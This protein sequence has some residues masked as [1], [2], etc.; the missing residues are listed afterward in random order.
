MQRAYD[1]IIHDVALQNLNVVFCL[2]RAGI[3]GADGATHHGAFDIAFMRSIPNMT[4][5][6]PMDECELRNMMF[7]AQNRPQ[8]PFSI[9]YPRGKTPNADWQK[10][11]ELIPI[12]KG[13]TLREGSSLAILTIGNTGNFVNE[14]SD[15]LLEADIDY[16]HYDM[17]F[18]KPIDEELL[19]KVFKKFTKIITVEDGVLKGGFGSA[20]LEFM[21]DNQYNAEVVRLGI[22]D[23][24]VE[25]GASHELYEICGYSP[26]DILNTAKKMMKPAIA[27]H[28]T[29][30]LRILQAFKFFKQ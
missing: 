26:N 16:A 23:A 18:V 10:P 19:H 25:H 13:R 7:T 9:R 15:K 12:G 28:E 6:A 14:I 27:N 11:F 29:H 4:V 3:V 17:R 22:P 20:V 24:F 8:G 21:A 1:Q 30:H 5:A 2:D